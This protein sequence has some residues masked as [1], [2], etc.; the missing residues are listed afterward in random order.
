M[1]FTPRARAPCN[2]GRSVCDST[3]L[4]C[5][6]HL[7]YDGEAA[8]GP[9]FKYHL[10]FYI[11]SP[12]S[13]YSRAETRVMLYR[14][15]NN[16]F[17][18]ASNPP[19]PLDDAARM[20]FSRLTQPPP[21]WK[22]VYLLH[23]PR[24]YQRDKKKGP[25]NKSGFLLLQERVPNLSIRYIPNFTLLV[26]LETLFPRVVST[27]KVTNYHLN[28]DGVPR[29]YAWLSSS[30]SLTQ[31]NHCCCYADEYNCYWRLLWK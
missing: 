19:S 25:E 5:L 1:S 30:W 13:L 4:M 28:P 23:L 12:I 21:V 10:A 20:G 22:L 9:P 15:G 3:P 27:N 7:V 8:R 2:L 16:I 26:I 24:L 29:V 11:R 6:Q 31:M 17:V 18:C 14:L